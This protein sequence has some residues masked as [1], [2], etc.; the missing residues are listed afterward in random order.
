MA[1][2]GQKNEHAHR[3][4]FFRAGGFDQVRLDNGKAIL[5]LDRLDH[6]LWAALGCPVDGL[7]I[8]RRTLELIDTDQDGRIRAA[9]VIA[10]VKWAAARLNDP[11]LLLERKAELPLSAIDDTA[12]EGRH[13][14]AAARRIL[15]K[16]NRPDAPSISLDDVADSEKIFAETRFNG[17]GIV[18]PAAADDPRIAAVIADIVAV[19]GGETDRSGKPGLSAAGVDRFFADLALWHDWWQQRTPSV[20]P[21]GEATDAAAS[22]VAPV[23]EKLDDYFTRCRLV[24]FDPRA[25][26]Q[27]NRSEA[28]WAALAERLLT[29]GDHDLAD[30]PLALAAAGRALPLADGLNPAWAEAIG[31]LNDAAV[32]PL[33]GEQDTLSEEDWRR[34][35]ATLAPYNAWLAGKPAIALGGLPAERLEDIRASDARAAIDD[36]IERDLAL[37]GEAA[38]LDSVERL[39]RYSR[40]L[41]VLLDNFVAFRDFY[42]RRHKAVFQAGTL[43]IDGRSCQLCVRVEDVDK[44]AALAVLSRIYLLYCDCRRR[45]EQSAERMTIAAAVTAGDADQLMVGRNGV[46]YDR[47]GR[48]WDATVVRIVEHPISLRQAFWSP[49]KKFAHLIGSQLEKLA[50]ARAKAIEDKVS[51]P[52]PAPAAA[53]KKPAAPPQAAPA[54][55]APPFDAGRFAGIFAAA[56][57]ALGAIGTAVASVITGLLNLPWWE[58]PIALAGAMILVSGPS[59]AIA[60]YKLHQRNLGPILDANGWA[61]NT[62]A[63]INI[64]FGTALT[65]IARLPEGSGRSLTDPYAEKRSPWGRYAA[66]AVAVAVV[67]AAWRLGWLSKLMM[68][69]GR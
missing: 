53:D 27:L 8:D 30:F 38:A 54:A 11:D 26:G 1:T 16:R 18:P 4:H 51:Q 32:A 21:L 40:D 12:E 14:L 7:E 39:L 31:K 23:A 13:L 20:L 42:T 65:E 49:Y 33:L 9:E 28:D 67:I 24:T 5:A 66:L 41:A 68:L 3:W 22:A 58:I 56:G 52:I 34:L 25:A 10:A 43:F 50:A 36:L 47:H 64:P 46:F 35:R 62:R 61:V 19:Q 37:A 69:V 29:P 15:A 60:S 48:D 63:R 59:V 17:D 45:G 55:P 57:L 6:K 2:D 44:H